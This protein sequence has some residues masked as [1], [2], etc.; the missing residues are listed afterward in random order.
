MNS[1]GIS[2]RNV[3]EH[4]QYLRERELLMKE[5][6]LIEQESELLRERELLVRNTNNPTV[7]QPR[8]DF[9]KKFLPVLPL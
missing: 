7:K 6:E 5:R 9:A 3:S 1:R 4:S 8:G 2:A